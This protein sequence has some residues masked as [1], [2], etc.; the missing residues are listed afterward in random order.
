MEAVCMNAQLTLCL[1]RSCAQ[2]ASAYGIAAEAGI[3]R[4]GDQV[5]DMSYCHTSDVGNGSTAVEDVVHRLAQVDWPATWQEEAYSR[6]AI[7]QRTVDQSQ[8]ASC[9][10][11]VCAEG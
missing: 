3:E 8:Q 7:L 5:L 6:D 4:E 2:C 1:H 10:L 11:H 9:A